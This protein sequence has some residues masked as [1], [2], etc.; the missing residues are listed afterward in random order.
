ML[1]NFFKV[2]FRDLTKD[3]TYTIISILGLSAAI[4]ISILIIVFNISLLTHDK[5]HVKG[6][7]IYQAFCKMDFL[8][9]GTQYSR[10]MSCLLGEALKEKYPEIKR[11]VTVKPDAPLILISGDN[12]GLSSEQEGFYSEASL[13]SIFSFPI[14]Q[15]MNNEVFKDDNSITISKKIA[16]SFFG[17]A[18]NAIGKRIILRRTFERKEVYVSSVFEDI[19][20]NSSIKFD[21]ILPLNSI[22]KEQSW[23]NTWG[24]LMASTYFELNPNVDADALNKKIKYFISDHNV[25]QKSELF[26]FKYED[27]FLKG[28]GTVNSMYIVVIGYILGFVILLIAAINF[29]NLATSRATKKAKEISLRKIIGSD[30][31]SLVIRFLTETFLLSLVA[32]LL[33]LLIAELLIPYINKSFNNFLVLSIPYG[34]LN[35]I[36]SILALWFTIGILSGLYPSFYLSAF[37]PIG[38]LKGVVDNARRIYLR[39]TLI[40]I[41]FVFST[42]FIFIVVVLYLQMK[43]ITDKVHGINL[44]QIVE[45]DLTDNLS[46]HLNAF[47]SDLKSNPEINNITFTSFEPTWIESETS[48][49][50]WEGKPEGLNDMFPVVTVG[51]NFLETFDI[52]LQEGRDFLQGDSLDKTNFIINEKMAKIIG[53]ENPVGMEMSFW[54]DQGE[55]IGVVKDFQN[56][57]M[58]E[59]IHPLI[60]RK[61]NNQCSYCFIK[62]NSRDIPGIL[63]FIEKT[64]NKYE[65]EYPIKYS[66]L[67]DQYLKRHVIITIFSRF[68]NLFSVIA[69]FI[70]CLG[71]FGLTAFTIQQKTKEV[72]IRKVLGASISSISIM[73]SQSV[74]K[75]VIIGALIALPLGFYLSRLLLQMFAYKIEI[76]PGIYLVSFAIVF[77]LAIATVLSQAIKAAVANPIESLK[78]E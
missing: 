6:D 57:T 38:S 8:N 77:V 35:F 75:L 59:K 21:Y 70:S 17:S 60:V 72:G 15:K 69:I 78:Y 9:A 71:L 25:Y 23:L 44:K 68:F 64:Y 16:V 37:S 28:P 4:S 42:L 48:D 76:T 62:I 3:R 50:K 7:R 5:F 14:L 52:Q 19:P 40:T 58:L 24:N 26:L 32:I 73:L 20:D 45:F 33:G 2:I 61:R 13:F 30:R 39:K 27:V 66:F 36:L 12:P 29:I 54:G 41:Q 10:T 1:K 22:R 11:S 67:D 18:S 65:E 34:N 31:K 49:P 47:T 74:I 53:K 51:D 46:K 55:I 63:K 43:F 56:C